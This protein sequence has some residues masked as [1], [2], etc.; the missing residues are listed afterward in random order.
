MSLKFFMDIQH[1]RVI[2]NRFYD[3]I[4]TTLI[5]LLLRHKLTDRKQ[6]N[7]KFVYLSI[8]FDFYDILGLYVGNI[9]LLLRKFFIFM[10]NIN[11][12]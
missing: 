9:R 7:Q 3:F 12:D 5:D 11:K 4:L 6:D 10:H 2:K 8:F 1:V